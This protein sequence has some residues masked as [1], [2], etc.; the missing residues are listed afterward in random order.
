MIIP[1]FRSAFAVDPYQRTL[2][3]A[4]AGE[5][6]PAP[7]EKSIYLHYPRLSAAQKTGFRIKDEG[8]SD[9]ISVRFRG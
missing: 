5:C 1:P 9:L 4:W 6:P 3:G 7:D 8:F 2:P